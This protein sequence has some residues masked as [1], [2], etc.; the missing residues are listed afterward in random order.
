MMK[1]M[2]MRDAFGRTIQDLRISLTDRCN[3]RCFY[4]M[5]EHMPTRA[6]REKVLSFEEI[7]RLSRILIGLGIRKI[8]LTGGEPLIRRSVSHLVRSLSRFKPDLRDIALTTNGSR[9][10]EEAKDLKAAGLDRVTFSLDSLERRRFAEIT[11]SDS[12]D[13]V[14]EAIQTAIELRFSPIKINTVVVRNRNDD[15]VVAFAE[16]ARRLG[17]CVRFIE[18]MP[19]DS[20]KAWKRD[21]VFTGA[22]IFRRISECFPLVAKGKREP[23][24]TAIEYIFK[25]GSPGEIGIIAPVSQNFCGDCS[26]LRL[27]ADGQLRTCLFSQKEYDLRSLLRSDASDEQIA[28]YILFAVSRKERGHQINEPDFLPPDRSMR[29]I[30]G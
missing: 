2:T 8:R 26:R 1:D 30:G 7:E 25:D 6:T 11:G 15:E 3:F 29:F 4:C 10:G 21:E 14:L 18:Y 27:M 23:G 28:D 22:E 24:K 20:A 19:L 16:F 12:L 5:P 13:K 9:F 17:V